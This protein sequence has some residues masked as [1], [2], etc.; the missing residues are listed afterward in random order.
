MFNIFLNMQKK[1][2]WFKLHDHE[3]V[4]SEIQW[5]ISS[6]LKAFSSIGQHVPYKL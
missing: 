1:F 5:C 3:N 6:L 4:R 2:K